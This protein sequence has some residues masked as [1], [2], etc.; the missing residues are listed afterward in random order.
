M[1]GPYLLAEKKNKGCI[2]TCVT[3]LVGLTKISWQVLTS[4]GSFCE[5]NDLYKVSLV[6]ATKV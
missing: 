3:I 5:L 4:A 1:T 2:S 6:V